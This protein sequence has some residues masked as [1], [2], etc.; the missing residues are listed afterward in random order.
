MLFC[1]SFGSREGSAEGPGNAEIGSPQSSVQGASTDFSIGACTGTAPQDLSESDLSPRTRG[2]VGERRADP[3]LR[4]ATVGAASPWATIFRPATR[5]WFAADSRFEQISEATEW[6]KSVAPGEAQRSPGL[7]GPGCAKPR[8]GDR[9][10]DRPGQVFA[11]FNL[12]G[13]HG[14]IHSGTPRDRTG[15]R[16]HRVLCDVCESSEGMEFQCGL[17]RISRRSK[18]NY[19]SS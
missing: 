7:E 11:V 10:N 8:R 6:C 12:G 14:F 1:S 9:M 2:S 18:R 19:R 13:T 16:I 17:S 4:G 15:W 5:G 3:G